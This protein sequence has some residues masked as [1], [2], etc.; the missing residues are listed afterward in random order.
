MLTKFFQKQLMMRKVLYSLIPIF[1]YSIYLHGLKF[2]LSTIFIFLF[3]SITEYFFTKSQNKK[4]S[5]AVLVSCALYALS[6]PPYAPIWISSIG[7]IFGITFAKMVFGGF[8]RN[9]FNPAI[10][11]RLFVYISFPVAFNSYAVDITAG[12]TPLT[13]FRNGYTF[14][15]IRLFL[16]NYLGAFGET[17][18]LLIILAAIYLIYTKT[19]NWKL[20]ISTLLSFSILN[21]ILYFANIINIDPLSSIFTGSFLFV[22]V[23]MVTDPV[24]APKQKLAIWLYGIL[25][26][27]SISLIRSFSLFPEG[28]SFAILLGN[29]FAPLFDELSKKIK[30]RKGA[31]A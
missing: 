21:S 14:S 28:T 18:S 13:I 23:F 10:A 15:K 29:S 1:I 6:I 8:G 7:I 12:A 27:L 17:S 2:I 9:V 16:G 20:M 24:T 31:K 4:I 25:I 26:G 22:T 30:E 5:E 19:A 3:G 11:A